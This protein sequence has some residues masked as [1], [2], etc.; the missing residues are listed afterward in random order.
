M[1]SLGLFMKGHVVHS[2]PTG[3][4]FSSNDAKMPKCKRKRKW[5]C[6][7]GCTACSWWKGVS[8]TLCHMERLLHS[9]AFSTTRPR[10]L[11]CP[12]PQHPIPESA[13]SRFGT[14]LLTG[15]RAPRKP[16]PPQPPSL[17]C[18]PT[19][20]PST[21]TEQAVETSVGPNQTEAMREGS[22]RMKTWATAHTACAA[23]VS[24]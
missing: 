9:A 17:P 13:F 15:C 20:L 24:G 14:L 19:W 22:P 12:L 6:W 3:G 4:G 18:G 11:T 5:S 23:S 21:A 1:L 2:F 7:K 8:A 16:T 10:F